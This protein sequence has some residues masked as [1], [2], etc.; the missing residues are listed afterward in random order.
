[1]ENTCIH[2]YMH[3][4]HCKPVNSCGLPYKSMFRESNTEH[5]SNRSTAYF[6]FLPG[7]LLH[8]MGSVFRAHNQPFF[9]T[10][11]CNQ[12]MHNINGYRTHIYSEQQSSSLLSILTYK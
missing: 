1:M 12:D 10:E 11:I 4:A 2:A 9:L 3:T 6:S 5:N 8:I 7:L